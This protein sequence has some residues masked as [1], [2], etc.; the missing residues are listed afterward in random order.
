[1]AEPMANKDIRRARL[2]DVRFAI[3]AL[4]TAFDGIVTLTGVF[5]DEADL[6]KSQGINVSLWTGL[7]W[8]CCCWPGASGYGSLS[9]RPTFRPA[10]R[11]ETSS[12][13]TSF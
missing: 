12:P 9:C 4:F 7:D 1:M 5:S 3:A 8:A 10:T 2:Y 6:A 11:P 13:S